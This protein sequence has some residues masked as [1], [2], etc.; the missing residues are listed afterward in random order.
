MVPQPHRRPFP[1]AL[2]AL[3]AASILV[4]VASGCGDRPDQAQEPPPTTTDPLADVDLVPLAPEP[5]PD[6]PVDGPPAGPGP[7]DPDDRPH[8]WTRG[9]DPRLDQ[10]WSHCA[11]GRGTACDEL[12]DA[13][14]VGSDYERFG[15]TCGDRTGVI[16]CTDLDAAA[17]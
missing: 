4:I 17:P 3:A 15:L 12:F 9:D 11:E 2:A 5:D 6:A 13:A 7:V 14:P 10:L 1:I 16:D 8:P